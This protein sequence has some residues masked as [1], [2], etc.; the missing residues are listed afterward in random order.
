MS[1]QIKVFVDGSEGTTGLEILK[2]LN[3]RSDI[4][5]LE[6]DPEQRKNV[7]ARANLHNQ[8]DISILCLPDSASREIVP[9]I[10]NPDTVVIDASTAF[11]T[12]PDWAFGLPELTEGQREKIKK[13]KR[14]ANPGCHST[15]Y[16]LLVRPLVDAGLLSPDALLSATSLTGYSGG[17]KKMIQQFESDPGEHL[18][19]CPYAIAMQHKH[20]PEMQQWSGLDNAPA[21]LPTVA[22]FYRGMIVTIPVHASQLVKPD[23]SAESITDAY[24]KHFAGEQF[25]NVFPANSPEMVSGG[26]MDP[27]A[28]AES[29]RAEIFVSG[30]GSKHFLL[31]CRIDNLCKGASGAAIQSL[32]IVTGVPEDTGL[33]A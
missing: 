25:I 29:Q 20:L 18:A 30:T 28:C 13:A 3:A 19:A 22:R 11:R 32:N 7:E 17:G 31:A 4:Q 8:A 14:I 27:T 6:I 10:T 15:A 2:Y 1:E 9:L 26:L 12:H 16:L 21:F 33:V 24:S 23:Q 5:I